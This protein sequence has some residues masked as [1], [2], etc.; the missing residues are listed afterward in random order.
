MSNI[1]SIY[2][3]IPFCLKKCNYC[4]FTSFEGKI[5]YQERYFN[6]LFKEIEK[7]LPSKI[8]NI[9]IGGGT[10]VL[11]SLK[12]YAKLFDKL[13]KKFEILPNSEITM[14]ANPKIQG[15]KYYQELRQMGVNRLSLGVQ[16][17]DDNILKILNRAH[18][19][20]EAVKAVEYAK[21]AGFDNISLDL[22][23][24]LPAQTLDNHVKSMEIAASLDVQHI[25]CYGLKIE[26]GT[27]FGV[28]MPDNMPDEDIVLS[29][30]FKTIE[31]LDEKGFEQYEI[32]NFAQNGFQSKH[33]LNYWKNGEYYAFGLAS[34][35]YLNG[36]RYSHGHNL[37][38]YLENPLKFESEQKLTQSEILEEEIFL[39]LRL[40][41][42]LEIQAVNEKF[43]IDFLS[44]YKKI[45][46]KYQKFEM[47][48]IEN[49]RVFLTL[50]GFIQ[51]NE[52]MSEFL[53]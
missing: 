42:G 6:A 53:S 20:D 16:S 24:G 29:M 7:A 43:Q 11:A 1:K 45:L 22:M 5:S 47:L 9:Y 37:K 31:T 12:N 36:I 48:K 8:F 33:N 17:F 19:G 34:H 10:P 50:E 38:E 23:Y 27:P 28:K 13:G 25:S 49:G 39:G 15:E 14:E 35:G 40:K 51:S 32:S 52:I 18:T 21:N 3:H 41:S 30:Y 26:K 44:K 4:N 2:I 46:D